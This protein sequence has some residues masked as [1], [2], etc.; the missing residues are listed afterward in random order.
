MSCVSRPSRLELPPR[1]VVGETTPVAGVAAILTLAA[2][3]DGAEE[4]TRLVTIPPGVNPRESA[5]R[6]EHFPPKPPASPTLSGSAAASSGPLSR[7]GKP[8]CTPRN[9]AGGGGRGLRERGR[10]DGDCPRHRDD[11]PRIRVV[12]LQCAFR[13]LR[14]R[15]LRSDP[16]HRRA[17]ESPPRPLEA[18]IRA[19]ILPA[20]LPA[21]PTRARVCSDR[22]LRAA[23][24]T[25]TG[26]GGAKTVRYLRRGEPRGREVLHILRLPILRGP[27]SSG[28][29]VRLGWPDPAPTGLTDKGLP[30]PGV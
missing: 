21:A 16:L 9:D 7:R 1:C 14:V 24:A 13:L 22:A 19:L 12:P 15:D 29:H 6:R 23:P 8:S 30:R 10:D 26:T 20:A 25:D 5:F 28:P 11:D 18:D 27:G 2:P 17:F 3:Q 4:F